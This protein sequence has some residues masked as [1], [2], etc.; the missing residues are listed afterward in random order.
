MDHIQLEVTS[1]CQIGCCNCDR[2][3]GIY[4]DKSYIPLD[5]IQRMVDV[6]I[7]KG[8]KW[9]RIDIIGGE[10]TYYPQFKEMLEVIKKYKD[11]NPRCKIRLSTNG[12]GKFVEEKLKEIPNWIQVRNSNKSSKQQ[13]FTAYNSAPFDN[14]ET[15]VKAC[16]VPWRCGIA[17]TPNGYFICNPGGSLSKVFQMD[18][19]IKEFD[20]VTPEKLLE[21]IPSL[22]KYCGISNCKSKHL[23]DVQEISESWEDALNK[24]K[25]DIEK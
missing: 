5:E 17:L 8:K 16:S 2:N 21:Q 4:P 22:C 3:C 20:D 7:E 12:F 6:S 23:T 13:E 11:W 25:G 9:S 24:L 10:P 15:E 18:I 19:G 14:G 1:F